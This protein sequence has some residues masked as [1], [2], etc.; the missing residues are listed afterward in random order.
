MAST[1]I[2]QITEEKIDELRQAVK[3][4]INEKILEEYL[5]LYIRLQEGKTVDIDY[6]MNRIDELRNTTSSVL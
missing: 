4:K 3:D 5:R 6:V 2:K 1:V